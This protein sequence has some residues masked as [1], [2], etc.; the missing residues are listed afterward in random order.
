MTLTSPNEKL[1]RVADIVRLFVIFFYEG[2]NFA[3]M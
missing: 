3:S 1:M 2:E